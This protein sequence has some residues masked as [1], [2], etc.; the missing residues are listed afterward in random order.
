MIASV[1]YRTTIEYFQSALK[2]VRQVNDYKLVYF[3]TSGEKS[4]DQVKIER[5]LT[6]I[7]SVKGQV[8]PSWSNA[9]NKLNKMRKQENDRNEESHLLKSVNKLIPNYNS[10]NDINEISGINDMLYQKDELGVFYQLSN[11]NNF[12]LTKLVVDWITKLFLILNN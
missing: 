5:H 2:V 11:E 3:E 10:N 7:S 6:R 1:L 12:N 4:S 8:H 9:L